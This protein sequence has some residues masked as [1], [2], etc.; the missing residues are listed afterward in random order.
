[1]SSSLTP[2]TSVDGILGAI[3][4]RIDVLGSAADGVAGGAHQS[5]TDQ[6]DRE[7]LLNHD[8]FSSSNGGS[9]AATRNGCHSGSAI[10]PEVIGETGSHRDRRGNV[11]VRL[12][13]LKD[14]IIRFV[15]KEPLPA[16]LYHELGKRPR[17][18]AELKPGLLEMI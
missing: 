15:V 1:M 7:N 8:V 2:L 16:V 9:N 5:G 13:I 3:C 11:R 4:D 10:F 17:I 6:S 14:E 18:A 12:V